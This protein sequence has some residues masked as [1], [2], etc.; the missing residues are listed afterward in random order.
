MF[1][2]LSYDSLF[3][4]GPAYIEK[5]VGMWFPAL[6]QRWVIIYNFDLIHLKRPASSLAKKLAYV[7]FNTILL[8]VVRSVTSV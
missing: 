8:S 4:N 3:I 1:K 2:H 7:K 5:V 6:L